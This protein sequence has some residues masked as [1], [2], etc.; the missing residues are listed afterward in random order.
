MYVPPY[1]VGAPSLRRADARQPKETAMNFL[2]AR[3]AARPLNAAGIM[4]RYLPT[5]AALLYPLAPLALYESGR[6]FALA[7]N[8]TD[9]LATGAL[10]SIAIS[11]T[12]SVPRAQS[13]GHSEIRRRHS[14]PPLRASRV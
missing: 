8:T 7:S 5:A 14:G 2:G 9:K 12:Y 1:T 11:L 13:R 3:A 6:Q 4:R 10:L